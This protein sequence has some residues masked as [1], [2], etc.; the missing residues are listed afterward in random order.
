VAHFS[1]SLKFIKE[2]LLLFRQKPLKE[3]FLGNRVGVDAAEQK[4]LNDLE[5]DFVRYE[6]IGG[7]QGRFQKGDLLHKGRGKV[8]LIPNE[9]GDPMAESLI[10]FS[11]DVS[12]TAGPDLY[13]YLSEHKSAN[14][15]EGSYLNAGML[16]GTKGSQVYVVGKNIDELNR[17][18]YLLVYCKQ[19]KVL[20]SP[21]EL[22]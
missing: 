7:R 2:S 20:F 16:K 9:L 12:V 15:D 17:Y 18:K 13:V 3:I 4:L 21:A 11:D 14:Q 1:L 5:K 22:K 6:K 19:F 10:V 8:Y